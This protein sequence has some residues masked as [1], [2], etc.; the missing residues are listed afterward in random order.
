MGNQCMGFYRPNLCYPNTFFSLWYK[1]PAAFMF[2]DGW[3]YDAVNQC[4]EW[5]SQRPTTQNVLWHCS[6]KAATKAGQ[7]DM[8][9]VEDGA[10][11]IF[12]VYLKDR[13]VPLI[14][15]LQNKIDKNME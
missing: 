2:V 5:T 12:S 8:I 3:L 1:S 11:R 9:R 7:A 10:D 6:M 14:H 13:E 4:A 15:F